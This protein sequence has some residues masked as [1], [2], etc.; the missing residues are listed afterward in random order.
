MALTMV[1]LLVADR[2]AQAHPEYSE[3]PEFFYGAISPDAIHIRD[4]NDKS[5]KNFF[6]LNNWITAHPEDVIAYWRTNREP[7]DIGYGVHVLTDG[8]WVPRYREK[9]PGILLP[10]GLLNTDIYY[11][12][13][14]VTDF[15][16]YGRSPR[17]QAI[18][19][20]IEGARTPENHPLLTAYEF[21]QWRRDILEAYRRPC[22]KSDP[23]RFI[24]EA[25]V[26]AFVEDS[27]SLIEETYKEYRIGIRI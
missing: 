27:L 17:L 8:Q 24:D 26:E 11:N 25:Y 7:F 21:S 16:L 12:D 14:F 20:M 2:W 5:R 10:T 4:G 13:T 18:L 23:V 19:K 6:H 1:H 15:R 22:P 3:D 9:L